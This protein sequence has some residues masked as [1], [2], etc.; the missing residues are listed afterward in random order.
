[1]QFETMI[2]ICYWPTTTVIIDDEMAFLQSTAD[3]L[4]TQSPVQMF[5]NPQEGIA[6][7]NKAR[8]ENL[9]EGF[10]SNE[11]DDRDTV[12]NMAED[13]SKLHL[14]AYDSKRTALITVVVMDYNLPKQNG[15]F[16]IK[17]LQDPVIQKLLL[18]GY[19]KPEEVIH[20]FN[21][22]FI[23]K[24]IGKNEQNSTEKLLDQ[25]NI[26]KAAYFEKLT[27]THL[28]PD[29]PLFKLLS[30]PKFITLFNN[31][32]EKHNIREFYL[33]DSLGSF[34][35]IDASGKMSI[36]ALT[37]DASLQGLDMLFD[38]CTE[39][40]QALMDAILNKTKMPFFIGKAPVLKKWPDYI[41]DCTRIKGTEMVYA[42]IENLH[43]YPI[44]P[45]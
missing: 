23:D 28:H 29:T 20:A 17:K 40:P 32:M 13:T 1:M 27:L 38:E 39:L 16:H 33:L 43:H 10:L 14:K 21:E 22:K 35:L 7:V 19:A 12:I 25:V 4:R 41:H 30:N 44:Q 36:L 37:N 24:Y 11:P 18:T 2:P 3:L 45:V 6:F 42:L 34:L 9:L 31:L 8:Q 5:V 26:L 15:L